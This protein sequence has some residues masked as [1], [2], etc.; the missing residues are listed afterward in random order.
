MCEDVPSKE[1]S[2]K[3]VRNGFILHFKL[4]DLCQQDEQIAF[5]DQMLNSRWPQDEAEL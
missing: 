4:P 3:V 2:S 1:W 5:Q